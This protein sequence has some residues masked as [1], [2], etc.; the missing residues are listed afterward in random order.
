MS[1]LIIAEAGVNHNGDRDLAFQ[2]VS[3]AADSGADAVKFQTFNAE[4]LAAATAPK[5]QYQKE[6]TETSES[7]LAMLKKL[8]LPA[9]WHKD[10]QDYAQQKGIIFISTAF[11]LQSL[12]YLQTLDL[13]FY[14]IP[15]GEITN[16]RLLWAF[17]ATG[18]PCI[19]STGMA[20]ISEVEQALAILAHGYSFD[21]EPRSLNE[22]WEFWSQPQAYEAIKDQVTLLHCTSCYPT[23]LDQVNLKAMDTLR[24]TFALPVGYSDHT[25]G[26]LVPVAAAARGAT[27]IEKHFT[28]G[29]HLPGP[30]QKASLEPHELKELVQQ[31]R[32]VEQTLG[33]GRKVPQP[34][35]RDTRQVA[36]QSLLVAHAVQQG[37][38]LDK[39]TLTTARTGQG[40]SAIH[41]WDYLG[42]PASKDYQPGEAL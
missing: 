41:Y 13:P 33:S 17:A 7:Q 37:E 11:D 8:E 10:L 25:Q 12:E 21:R 42:T 39:T 23:P 15:S 40:I 34:A 38:T 32:A 19:L 27:I 20:T 24:A 9:S 31:V 35:E 4:R 22:T 5:A 36:R 1:V 26:L 14:K 16:A 2:L 6:N 30:D 29:R 18:K 3:A 28:L